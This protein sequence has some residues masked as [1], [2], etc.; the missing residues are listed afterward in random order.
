MKIGDTIKYKGE[1]FVIL[2][3]YGNGFKEVAGDVGFQNELV[4]KSEI[5]P[6]AHY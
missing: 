5:D 2:Y 3:I 4:H 1:S 6:I